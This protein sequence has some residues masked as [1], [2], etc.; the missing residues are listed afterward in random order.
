MTGQD[1]RLEAP[2][3]VRETVA[4][5]WR[6]VL[7]HRDFGPDDDFFEHGGDP[8][9]ATTVLFLLED[10]FG[11]RV[12]LSAFRE[13]ATVAGVTAIVDSLR[14]GGGVGPAAVAFS[15]EGML[16]QEWFAPGTQNLPG[17]ARR[18][19]GPL[20][21]AVLG[22][23][24]D[25]IVRRHG[26]LRTTFALRNGRMVQVVRA[27]RSLKLGVT[28]LSGLDATEREAEVECLVSQ[29]GRR[30]FD[31]GAGP[32]FDPTLLRLGDDDHVLVIRAH[33]AVFDDWS[34][35]V[36]R[37]E[38]AALYSAYAEGGA[39]PLPELPVQFA[40]FSRRQ[41]GRLA[42]SAGARQMEFWRR[43]LAGAP[44]A[45][46]LAI[47]D[48]ELP[49]GSPQHAG[50]PISLALPAQLSDQLRALAR[51]ERTTVYTTMLAAFGV[52][53][54]RHTGQEDLLLATVVANRNRTELEGVI[55]CFTKKVPLRLNLS[56]APTFAE[57]L[58]RSRRALLGALSNQDLPF[59]A[60]VQDVLGAAAS[61][62]GLVPQVALMFQGVTP[63]Q[64]LT[65]P[66]VKTAGF[67]TSARARRAH[68]MAAAH[69]P[70]PA[71]P[72]GS[73]LYL[74]TFLILTLI[75]SPEELSFLARGAFHGPAV[76]E[77]MTSFRALLFGIA[78]D[79]A[80]RV[81]ELAILDDQGT[82]KAPN[83][84]VKRLGPRVGEAD[85]RGFRV[86]PE[87][88]RAALLDC[89]GVRDAVVVLHQ[90]RLAAFVVADG[91]P[92]RWPGCARICG[93]GCPAMPGPPRCSR[94]P[95]CPSMTWR[96]PGAG[97]SRPARSTAS[98]ARSGPR[99]STSSG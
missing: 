47:D 6:R 86:E 83:G 45:T 77:L 23:A 62:H 91:E 78:A 29:A 33:H 9:A 43:E 40:D 51:R 71:L 85:L 44:F 36:F 74:G 90:E 79:P 46:Q 69:D 73:G 60:V 94:C 76:S 75:E 26:A 89:P 92:R 39:S 8:F 56:G 25:E 34:V 21:V 7:G 11:V 14:S 4:A 52:L 37:R 24:L 10:A 1:E 57:V 64:E 87:R 82:A 12:P 28:D 96:P 65:L 30:P 68:F 15:Q 38:L 16:W 22:R 67:E 70:A 66:G 88:I 31:L 99:R 98:W 2:A 3:A 63:R 35:G 5:I 13:A 18:F 20:D 49:E 72:W 41:R 93:R 17:L 42:G 27:H 61:S 54:H 80:R 58:A 32:L 81:S 55:G 48:P 95:A 59:E 19:L 53:V 50:E 84:R 97:S